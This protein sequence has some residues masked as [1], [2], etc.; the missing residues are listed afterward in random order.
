MLSTARLL[1]RHCPEFSTEMGRNTVSVGACTKSFGGKTTAETAGLF[2]DAKLDCAELCFCQSD[3]GGW[4]YNFS[5]Y[6]MLPKVFDVRKAIKTFEDHG[7]KVCAVGIYNCMWFGDAE[8]RAASVRYFSDYC[9]IA[10]ECGVKLVTT[11]T[12]ALTLRG[13]AFRST[14]GFSDMVYEVFTLCAVE[15]AKRGIS[16][17]VECSENDAIADYDGFMKLKGYVAEA[18][19]S[20]DMLKYI[21]IPPADIP[22]EAVIM[23]IRDR[24]KDERYYRRFGDGDTD[25]SG[26]SKNISVYGGVPAI[27][28]YVNSENLLQTAER[29]RSSLNDE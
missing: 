11:H 28:E 5:G 27:L 26:F 3:L 16:I 29:F 4:K 9:D 21:G 18:L 20:G 1:V 17:A 8:K 6:E 15:A 25:F 10:A 14:P 13:N 24:K 2:A 7:I 19:G 12:G 22:A 23:H